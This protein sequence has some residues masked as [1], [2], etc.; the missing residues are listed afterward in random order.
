MVIH[1]HLFPPPHS[2]A[3]AAPRTHPSFVCKTEGITALAA[4][5]F[6]AGR[7]SL[8]EILGLSKARLRSPVAGGTGL[9]GPPAGLVITADR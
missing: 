6:G 4:S 7:L 8:F 1:E 9:P 5:S 2:P 3:E